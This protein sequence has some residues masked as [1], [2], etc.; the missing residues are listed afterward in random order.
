MPL[1]T[2]WWIP[3]IRIEHNYFFGVTRIGVDGMH[4]QFPKSLCKISV[5]YWSE[6]LILKKQDLMLDK[7][8][9]N[10]IT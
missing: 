7:I 1:I 5:L 10:F 4:M 9:R 3:I 2:I 6:R 8:C